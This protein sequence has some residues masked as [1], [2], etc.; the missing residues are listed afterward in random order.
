MKRLICSLDGTWNND[1]PDQIVTNVVKLHRCILPADGAGVQQIAR[2]ITGIESAKGTANQFLKGAVG[3][4]VDEK[5][6][7]AY[8]FLAANYAAGDEIY[9]F[10]FSRGAFQARSLAG[11]ITMAGLAKAGAGF[12]YPDAWDLYRQPASARNAATLKKLRAAA[13]TGV[14]IRCIGAF[15]TVGNL[16]NPFF[17]GGPFNGRFKFHDMRLHDTVGVAL[18]ALSIDE[19]RGPFRP[20]LWTKPREAVPRPD[21]HVEQMWFAGSHADVGGGYADTGLSDIPLAWMAERIAAK[22]GLALDME[23]LRSIAKPDVH[24]VQHASDTGRIFG[25]SKVLPF[26]RLINQTTAAIPVMR[27]ML[28]GTWR[29]T[30]LSRRQTGINEQVHESV[31]ER[32]GKP[33]PVQR[34][35]T[36][37]SLVYRPVNLKALMAARRYANPEAGRAEP[38]HALRPKVKLVTVHGTGSGD[39]VP[40]GSRWW[41]LGS[42]FQ[43]ELAKRLNLDP[44]RVEVVAFQWGDGPNS[45]AARRAAGKALYEQLKSYDRSCEDYHVIGHSHGGSVIH[46]ALMQSILRGRPFERLKSWSSV[47]TP[48][49]DYIPRRYL[50][51]RL[52]GTGLMIFATAIGAFAAAAAVL[53]R[54]FTEVQAKAPGT[55]AAYFSEVVAIVA[56]SPVVYGLLAL[57]SVYIIDR[58]RGGWYSVEQK[59]RAARLY[60]SRW[61][62]VFHRDDEAISALSNV[63]YANGPIVPPTFLQPLAGL[64]PLALVVAISFAYVDRLDT[65]EEFTLKGLV[66]PF[67]NNNNVVPWVWYAGLLVI[68]PL[69][70]IAAARGL[71]ALLRMV[72]TAAGWPLAMLIDKVVWSSVRLQAWGDDRTR[73]TVAGIASH[74]PEFPD[75]FG[76]L[77]E[78]LSSHLSLYS[79]KN[80]VITLKRVRQALGMVQRPQ[81]HADVRAH[82]A[83]QLNWGELIHTTYFDIPEFIDLTALHLHEAGMAPLDTAQGFDAGREEVRG[84]RQLFNTTVAPVPAP[85]PAPAPAAANASA[86]ATPPAGEVQRVRDQGAQQPA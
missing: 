83:D 76:P 30:K 54:A 69:V 75:L 70:F 84:W 2:Y 65:I 86:A 66:L 67:I 55:K 24:G 15:D 22:T 48:F 40:K 3:I 45:E 11:F 29:A 7:E 27:R 10:G 44:A 53:F 9:L 12:N 82:L 74:P 25:W 47:G 1:D 57:A 26:I 31:V 19:I 23:K 79:E 17:S 39:P 8:E 20:T 71:V 78:P 32:Y 37:L 49:L 73:E 50:Y 85:A 62:G 28:L 43:T 13:D 51:S 14:R 60:A 63:R 59:R 18:H 77:P 35:G 38:D 64:I 52:H 42:P 72:V 41:Q 68:S 61:F 80:A 56:A 21:Q 6:K 33:V 46:H 58:W 36:L 5:I 34:D 16:G 4:Q 81:A